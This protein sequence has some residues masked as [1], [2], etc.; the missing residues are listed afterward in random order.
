MRRKNN[1]YNHEPS[2]EEVELTLSEALELN[3]RYA[4]LLNECEAALQD[5]RA[6]LAD[7]AKEIERLGTVSDYWHDAYDELWANAMGC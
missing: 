2:I 3:E 4:L 7:D 6:Q 1:M 5:A